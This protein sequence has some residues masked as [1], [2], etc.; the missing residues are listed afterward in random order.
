M[1][2]VRGEKFDYFAYFHACGRAALGAA[3]Y[4]HETFSAFDP[5]ALTRQVDELHKIEND[6]DGLKHDMLRHLAREFMTPI[7]LEDIISLSQ[8]LDNVVD[9]IDDVMQRVNMYAANIQTLRP[10]MLSFTSLIVRCCRALE[11][12]LEEFKHFRKSKGIMAQLIE[13]NTI[14]SEGDAL[15]ATSMK[16][17]YTEDADMRHVIIWTNI[18]ECLESCLD[19]CEDVA[20][21]IE[22]VIMKN[23]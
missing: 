23:T 10:E 19:F 7:E 4:L 1:G 20:D 9:A 16:Q 18:F 6:A 14:E 3:T 17:L 22:S 12:A 21:I 13:I 8:D 2:K 11:T 15:F 5:D